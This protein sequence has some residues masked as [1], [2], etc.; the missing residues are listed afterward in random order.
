MA[1]I[2]DKIRDLEAIVGAGVERY[3]KEGSLEPEYVKFTVVRKIK[4]VSGDICRNIK[5]RRYHTLDGAEGKDRI[6]VNHYTSVS[7]LF[8]MLHSA[9]DGQNASLRLYDSVHLND[10]AEGQILVK[11]FEQQHDWIKL[12]PSHPSFAYIASFV[13]PCTD[14]INHSGDK[15]LVFWLIYG[16]ECEGCSLKLN[17]PKSQLRRV[18]YSADEACRTGKALLPVLDS[19][20]PLA[21]VSNDI[22]V[23]L[24]KGFFESL[25]GIQYLYKSDA[26]RFENECRF[27]VG[28][29]NVSQEG[30]HYEVSDKSPVIVRH[31]WEHKDL[32]IGNIF[33]SGSSITIGSRVPDFDD[34]E[35][36]FNNLIDRI[37]SRLKENKEPQIRPRICP[38]KIQY[39]K[40]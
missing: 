17:L 34:L 8:S 24:A 21:D 40:I 15:N 27:L 37:N 25:E 38:S 4:E 28:D 26:Y 2:K 10:P 9:A 29:S 33:G 32:G 16:R 18:S 3:T 12:E 13:G 35:R 5:R 1:P 30:I 14:R 19:I 22:R 36:A 23:I 39:R 11:Y 31:Y 6:L 7:A 20:K